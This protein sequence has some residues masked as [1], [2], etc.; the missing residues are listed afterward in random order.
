MV[1]EP[2]LKH[3]RRKGNLTRFIYL[4]SN[5]LK[6]I[7]YFLDEQTILFKE[8]TNYNLLYFENRAKYT[9]S[10]LKHSGII[11]NIWKNTTQWLGKTS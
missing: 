7:K 1:N 3:K 11:I 2:N 9:C 5:I 10:N 4:T 6:N 8:L